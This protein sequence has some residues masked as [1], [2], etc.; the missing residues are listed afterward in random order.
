MNTVVV[1]IVKDYELKPYIG[2]FRN[3]ATDTIYHNATCVHRPCGRVSKGG[4]V[5]R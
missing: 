3:K 1:R 2:G 4:V 5:P